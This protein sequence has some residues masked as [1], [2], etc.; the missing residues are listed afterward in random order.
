MAA[1]SGVFD[2]NN[3]TPR[4]AYERLTEFLAVLGI[5]VEAEQ[6]ESETP[7]ESPD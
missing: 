3:V 5:A 4:M 6:I 1:A 2:I 7:K